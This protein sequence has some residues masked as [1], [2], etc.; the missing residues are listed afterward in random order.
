MAQSLGELEQD[1]LQ[2]SSEDRAKLVVS[3]LCSLEETAEDPFEVEKLWL[4][5]ARRRAQEIEDDTEVAIPAADVVAK[6][7]VKYDRK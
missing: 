5:E 4:N 2:L 6:L 1:A 3:L 7:K